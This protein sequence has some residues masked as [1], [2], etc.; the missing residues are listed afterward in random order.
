M[1]EKQNE[2]LAAL[3]SAIETLEWMAGCSS[4]NRDD[5]EAAI[6]E[7]RAVIAKYQREEV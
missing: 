4:P 7:G 6:E 3:V 1:D 2:L 5:V